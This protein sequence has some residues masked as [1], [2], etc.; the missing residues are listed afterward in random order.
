MK[1]RLLNALEPAGLVQRFLSYPPEGFTALDELPMP[2]FQ[3]PFDLLTTADDELKERIRRLPKQSW[4]QRF[5]T[6]RTAF[7]GTTVSEYAWL[8]SEPDVQG[9]ARTVHHKLGR[10]YALTIIKD[11]PE[12]SPLLSAHANAQSNALVSACV[13]QGFIPLQGQALAYVPIDFPDTETYL[14]RLPKDARRYLTRKL[15]KRD[16]LGI[17]QV[18][19]GKA[20]A[21]EERV[22]QYYAL[23][24]SVYAQSEIHFDLLSKE[25]LA[26]VLRDESSKGLVFEYYRADSNELIGW[27]L[28]FEHEGRLVDKYIGLS[29]PESR[30]LSLYFVS[31]MVNLEYA[32][33]Q[34]LSHYI[35]GWTDPGVKALLGADFTPTRHLIY[36][37]NPVLRAIARRL[38]GHFEMDKSWLKQT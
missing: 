5:L 33:A 15:R 23:Y 34:G 28:C 22:D 13:E 12:D 19:T 17:S 24:R 25:F 35:A 10:R 1:P 27:N 14:S 16:Q 29:Y 7:V 9:L 36:V 38:L 8:P 3:A 26:S 2:A 30:E 20:F 31:W 11:L 6:V 18:K 21:S 37:R 4:W 32:L